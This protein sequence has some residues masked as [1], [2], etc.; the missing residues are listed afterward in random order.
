MTSR[1]WATILQA[2]VLLSLCAACAI[3]DPLA[4][5]FSAATAGKPLDRIEG[6]AVRI[7]SVVD[8]RKSKEDLGVFEAQVV[9]GRQV[10]SWLQQAVESLNSPDVETVGLN[11]DRAMT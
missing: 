2:G 1:V 3:T 5:D 6:Y 9:E 10:M 4:I 8:D 7:A 11:K